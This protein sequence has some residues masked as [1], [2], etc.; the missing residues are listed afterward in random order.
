MISVEKRNHSEPTCVLHAF[1]AMADNSR[2]AT[3]AGIRLR[4]SMKFY[5]MR[6]P[7][8]L[9]LIILEAIIQQTCSNWAFAAAVCKEWQRFIEKRKF[10]RLKLKV[11]GLDNLER[12]SIRQRNLVRYI[13][14]DIELPTYTCRSCKRTESESWMQRNN[15]IISKGI[16]KLFYILST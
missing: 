11:P 3:P 16:W 14:F 12:L 10:H 15:F 13:S 9:R 8:E 5:W 1:A 7:T 2:N 4:S 6:L